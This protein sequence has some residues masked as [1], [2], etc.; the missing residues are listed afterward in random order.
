MNF[1]ERLNKLVLACTSYGG[2][3]HVPPSPEVL[4]AFASTAGL[5]SGERIRQYLT[6][7][8]TPEFVADNASQVDKFCDLREQNE[9]PFDV[10]QAQLLSATTFD[11]GSRVQE[12]AAQT[13]VITGD[14]DSVVP[15]Q[16]SV[17]LA[18]Q[19]PNARL[20]VINNAGHMVFVEQADKF[21]QIV[22]DFLTS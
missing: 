12:I 7:A 9:V 13:L 15:M 17:N 14:R 8:F 6:M 21:N 5:N 10:Y 16:N 11:T 2:A 22:K 4:S 20:E 19:I 1:P 3:G 18:S